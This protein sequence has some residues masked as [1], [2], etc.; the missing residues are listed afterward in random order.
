MFFTLAAQGSENANSPTVDRNVP[1]AEA[2][3]TVEVTATLDGGLTE[4]S[5]QGP[6]LEDKRLRTADTAQLLEDLPGVSF[7]TGGGLSSLPVL[8]GLADD[9]L[10]VL[11]DGAPITAS[12]PNH[13]NPA[14]STIAP[15]TVTGIRVFAGLTPVSQGGDSIGGTIQVGTFRPVFAKPGEGVLESGS[16]FGSTRSVNNSTIFGFSENLAGEHLGLGLTGSLTHAGNDKDGHGDR[17]TSTY[18]QAGNLGLDLAAKVDEQVLTLHAGYQSIPKQG[19]VN[20]QMDMVGNESTSLVLGDRAVFSWGV[21][22]AKAYLENTRHEMNIGQDKSTFPMP[23]FMPM[24]THGKDLGYSLKA[25]LPFGQGQ[26]L[27]LGHELHNYTLN[28]WWPP[29]AGTAPTMGPDTFQ[30]IHD[31]H[32]DQFGLFAE[33]ESRWSPQVVTLLGVRNDQI[34]TDAGNVQGYSSMAYG[35]DA[36]TFNS[37]NH[38]RKDRNWDLTALARVEPTSTASY[39][40]G[41]ASKSQSPNLYERY[42]WSTNRMASGMINWFGDGNYYVGNPDLKP[43]VADRLSMTG[44]WHDSARREWE[45]KATP[46]YTRIHDF[47]DVNVIGTMRYGL[48]TFHQLQFANHNAEIYGL[49]LAAQ[50]RVWEDGS[51]GTGRLKGTVAYVRGKNTDTGQSLYHMMPLNARLALEQTTAAWSNAVEVQCVDRKSQVDPNRLEPQTPGY[52][53]VHLRSGRH[54]RTVRMELGITN[55]FNR[56]YALPLGGVNFDPFM[57]SGWTGAIQPLAGQGRS[58]NLSAGIH[59]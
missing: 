40:F 51:L 43:E 36:D 30:S 49:D 8:D 42:A 28:D 46:Y 14:L 29:V 5:L 11:I 3:A 20:Q 32:R 48:S 25:E 56:Y 19:F 13:M 2:S 4:T 15:A 38:A 45:V 44:A 55:L 16:L 50:V 18:H 12:C 39:E 37:Q 7:Y 21:L 24:D 26:L 52:T 10:K 58:V 53:L 9:R 17:V 54:W 47:I 41:Y 31:G 59:F 1:V 22:E 57:A 6:A 33:L 23:M 34:R 27:R 35:T